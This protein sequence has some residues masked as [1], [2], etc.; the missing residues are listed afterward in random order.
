MRWATR[1]AAGAVVLERAADE[2]RHQRYRVRVEPGPGGSVAAE[3]GYLREAGKPAVFHVSLL[4]LL[5][6]VAVGALWGYRGG[7][8][9]V[10]GQGFSNSVTQYDDLTAGAWFKASSLKPFN[11]LVKDFDV[12]F[13]TGPVQTG[14]A[15]LFRADLD[16]TDAP[17]DPTRPVVLEVN[18][19]LNVDGSTV[20]LI[21]HGYARV[22]HG[23]GRPGQRGVLRTGRVPAAGRQLHLRRRRQGPGRPAGAHRAAG[24]LPAE[25]GTGRQPGAGLGVTRLRST[26]RCSST[27]GPGR[28]CRRRASPRASTPW[29]PPG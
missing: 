14:A 23:Q 5:L 26:R 9:V 6:G 27:S 7:S 25:H 3:R 19:P 29:T 17:G 16:V 4:F 11:V 1:R 22:R 28:R 20:H 15:R 2:L 12:K 8:V 21:G 24:L 18:R 10:V 13:E